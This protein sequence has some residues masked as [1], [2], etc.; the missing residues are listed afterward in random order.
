MVLSKPVVPNP[1]TALI[2]Q[3]M[4]SLLSGVVGSAVLGGERL[5]VVSAL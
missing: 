1:Q 2:V 5:A 4:Y 3:G